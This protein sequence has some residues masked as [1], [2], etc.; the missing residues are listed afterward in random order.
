MQCKIQH[1][2]IYPGQNTVIAQT[3]QTAL[4]ILCRYF[5]LLNRQDQQYK[6]QYYYYCDILNKVI[7]RFIA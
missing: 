5:F 6:W 1:H 3:V 2:S 4:K 7:A